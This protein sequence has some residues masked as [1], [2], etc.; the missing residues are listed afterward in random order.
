MRRVPS[1]L[2][3][4]YS[5]PV[6]RKSL[7]TTDLAEAQMR[8]DAME[9]A[10]EAYWTTLRLEGRSTDLDQRKY[11]AA[12]QR[13]KALSYKYMTA[14]ELASSASVE[15]LVSRIEYLT[16]TK[17]TKKADADALLGRIEKPSVGLNDAFRVVVNEVQAT[18]LRAKDD[19][20]RSDWLK[21]KQRSIDLFV[22]LY[23]DLPIEEIS[24]DIGR[25]FFNYWKERVLGAD[26]NPVTGNYAN[27]H[28]GNIRTLLNEYWGHL[29]EDHDNPL[30]GFSFSNK[31]KSK[32]LPFRV[33]QICDNFLRPG[34]FQHMNREAR[35]ALYMLIETGA[36]LSEIVTL[37]PEDFRLDDEFPHVLVF[38][39]EGR[40]VK[41]SNSNRIIPLVGVSLEAAKLAA[42]GGGFPHYRVRRK[43]LS[44]TLGKFCR[45]N[46]FFETGQSVYSLRHSFEDRMKEARIDVEMRKYLMGHDI[47]RQEYGS[48][49]SLKFKW[50]AVKSIELPFDAAIFSDIS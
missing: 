45:E 20:G 1:D 39:R 30:E 2:E 12:S 17:S 7:K 37:Q 26:G 28:L 5:N 46:N 18:A 50:E 27:R 22:E 31:R 32:R 44:A 40:G 6:I 34:A 9:V 15:D 21:G 41:T 49:A 13:A 36:R 35:L 33:E 47:D 10:D 23:G 42:A 4:H 14:E 11:E 8:R 24:R 3:G 19:E 25:Q 16:S 29:G 38:E 48:Y 43:G